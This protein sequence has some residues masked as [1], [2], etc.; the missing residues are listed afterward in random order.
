MMSKNGS[1]AHMRAKNWLSLLLTILPVLILSCVTKETPATETYQET[2]YQQET[3]TATEEYEV[4]TPYSSNL[5]HMEKEVDSETLLFL[6]NK[7]KDGN[8]RWT[9][10]TPFGSTAVNT[11]EPKTA[12]QNH[13]IAITGTQ[14][15]APLKEKRS[16]VTVELFIGRDPAAIAKDFN[17]LNAAPKGMSEQIFRLVL[18]DHPELLDGVAIQAAGYVGSTTARDDPIGTAG[19]EYSFD[20]MFARDGWAMVAVDAV[21]ARCIFTLSVDYVWDDVK[22]ETRQVT[23]SREIP[24]QVQKERTVIKT[25]KV[26]FWEALFSK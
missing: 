12:G 2:E 8:I 3:Y 18:M 17:A 13:R 11:F 15:K 19:I 9:Q 25:Q 14:Y 26:P 23:K 5:F 10:W 4:K 24:I 7:G 16:E 20:E 22:I 21:E 6:F 1:Q